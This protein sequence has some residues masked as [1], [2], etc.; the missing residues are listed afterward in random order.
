MK[1]TLQNYDLIFIILKALYRYIEINSF[2][3]IEIS[4]VAYIMILH[5]TQH[6]GT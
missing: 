6:D 1:L 2:I 5:F 3:I 4:I